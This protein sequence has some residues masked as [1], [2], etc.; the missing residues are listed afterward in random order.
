V[1]A[2]EWLARFVARSCEDFS[3]EAAGTSKDDARGRMLSYRGS[4]EE[5]SWR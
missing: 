2:V 1:T 3:E 4:R 5:E